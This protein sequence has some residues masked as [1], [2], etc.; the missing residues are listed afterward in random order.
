MTE[1]RSLRPEIFDTELLQ[2]RRERGDRRKGQF[3]I[4]R[5]VSDLAERLL[6]IDRNFAAVVYFGPIKGWT[7]L[8]SCL[9]EQKISGP[10][11]INPDPASLPEQSF[12]L[13]ISLLRV[14][15]ENDPGGY[16]AALGK[17][18]Q[19]DGLLMAAFFGGDSLED[20]RR[21]F[22]SA[23]TEFMGGISP[24]IAPFANHTQAAELLAR[25]GLK[26]PVVDIDRFTVAYQ[27]FETLVADLRD[28]GETN[29]VR[30]RETAYLGKAFLAY[31]KS[32][33]PRPAPSEPYLCKFEI[34]WI[35]AWAAH[36]N[37]Q[38]PLKPGSAKMPLAQ[39]LSDIQKRAEP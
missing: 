4:D 15:S 27:K 24:R 13:C 25:A 22:Y 39:A 36:E 30:V 37:Q 19:P 32:A 16:I 20:L 34:L 23:D 31:L 5:C 35:T 17:A 29:A 21:A 8:K 11:L 9:P 2:K 6:D 14:Q 1:N 18:L 12:D 28:L 7:D 10:V 26:L 3:F 38:K 33:Y